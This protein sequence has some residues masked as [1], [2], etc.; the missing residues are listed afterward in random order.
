MNVPP[1]YRSGIREETSLPQIRDE[2]NRTTSVGTYSGYI[3]QKNSENMLLV[4]S[5]IVSGS[6]GFKKT[7]DALLK[8]FRIRIY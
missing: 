4:S 8:Q 6:Q 2:R 7:L 5:E 1:H 3:L